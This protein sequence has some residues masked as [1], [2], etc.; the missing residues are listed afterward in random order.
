[1]NMLLTLES[2]YILQVLW[3]RISWGIGGAATRGSCT[4]QWCRYVIYHCLLFFSDSWSDQ[5]TLKSWETILQVITENVLSFFFFLFFFPFLF[6]ICGWSTYFKRDPS[7]FC[8]KQNVLFF[9]FFFEGEKSNDF[10]RYC[11]PFPPLSLQFSNITR[12]WH[13]CSRSEPSLEFASVYCIWTFHLLKHI[14]RWKWWLILGWNGPADDN[15]TDQ[16]I[17]AGWKPQYAQNCFQD[18]KT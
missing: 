14:F 18:S 17:S 11:Q 7:V 13:H 2:D 5:V 3:D 4:V 1:M 15:I 10:I 8:F 12:R 9:S 6:W 16:I